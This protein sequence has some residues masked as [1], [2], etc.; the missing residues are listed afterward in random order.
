MFWEIQPQPQ[1]SAQVKCSRYLSVGSY[2]A[3]KV[4]K[5]RSYNVQLE[6]KA[7]VVAKMKSKEAGI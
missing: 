2:R 5:K 6:L 3:K 1:I 4:Q 7:V